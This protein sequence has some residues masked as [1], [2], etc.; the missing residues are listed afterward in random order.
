MAVKKDATFNDILSFSPSKL[1]RKGLKAE[2]LKKVVKL[3]DMYGW[4][5]DNY[6]HTGVSCN[7]IREHVVDKPAVTYGRKPTDAEVDKAF[8]E[9]EAFQK[10]VD[11]ETATP[12]VTQ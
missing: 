11:A 3:L 8:E 10:K 7:L 4:I 5:L 1:L 9:A 6:T 2:E 12:V